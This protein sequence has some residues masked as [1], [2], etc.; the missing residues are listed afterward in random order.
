MFRGAFESYVDALKA[1]ADD[2]IHLLDK[3]INLYYDGDEF[4]K[5]IVEKMMENSEDWKII[6]DDVIKEK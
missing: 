4:K 3:P 5:E 6:T 2:E 1:F